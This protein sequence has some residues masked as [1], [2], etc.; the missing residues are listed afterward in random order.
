MNKSIFPIE[1]DNLDN[2]FHSYHYWPFYN[3]GLTTRGCCLIALLPPFCSL[4]IKK[5]KLTV[6]SF[7]VV[8][9]LQNDKETVI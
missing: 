1:L 5:T 6:T 8:S 9:Q 4:T 3:L 7:K 2:I